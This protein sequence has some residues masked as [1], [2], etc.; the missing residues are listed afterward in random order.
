MAWRM[1]TES[2]GQLSSQCFSFTRSGLQ[3]P[4]LVAPLLKVLKIFFSNYTQTTEYYQ[5]MWHD[6]G[7]ME[8]KQ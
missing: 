4:C 7:K 5:N 3:I 2:R 6:K 8:Q 1:V